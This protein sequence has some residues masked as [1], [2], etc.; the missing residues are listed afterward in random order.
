MIDAWQQIW[1]MFANDIGGK[2]AYQADFEVY[3]Q[4]AV[5]PNNTI[6]DIHIGLTNE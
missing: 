2:R 1:R 5:D 6:V 4:R 3:N